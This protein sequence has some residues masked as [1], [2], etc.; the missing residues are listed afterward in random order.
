MLEM[1]TGALDRLITAIQA[2]GR[3]FKAL[4]LAAGLGQNYV[5]QLVK[6]RKEPTLERLA[7]VLTVLGRASALYVITGV[8]MTAEDEQLLQ[9]ATTLSDEQK[10]SAIHF[11]QTLQDSSNN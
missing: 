6:D 7:A 9:V 10:R 2:D 4:S 11:F 1:K 3:D 5:Q 8:E